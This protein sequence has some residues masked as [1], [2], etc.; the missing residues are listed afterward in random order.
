MTY[1]DVSNLAQD[2]AFSS[3][4]AGCLSMEA[5]GKDDHL[6]GECLRNPTY[7]ASYFMP[8]ISAAP[9]FAETFAAGG[10]EA[11]EDGQILS[12]V[13]ANW[14]AVSALYPAPVVE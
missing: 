8:W 12:A 7:G 4:V 14:D 5:Q 6:A 11:V 10:Q 13:Q 2:P 3:R 9:G 1:Q